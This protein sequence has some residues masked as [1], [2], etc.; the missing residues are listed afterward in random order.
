MRGRPSG[1]FSFLVSLC[2]DVRIFSC[3]IGKL[4]WR[5]A[6]SFGCDCRNLEIV[7]SNVGLLQAI[8]WVESFGFS[9]CNSVCSMLR[10]GIYPYLSRLFGFWSQFGV[11]NGLVGVLLRWSIFK[12]TS[13]HPVYVASLALSWNP[14]LVRSVPGV[15][16]S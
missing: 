11:S 12:G 2:T 7:F 9:L 10:R 1:R 14:F 8:F 16:A 15:S 4:I 3:Q 5:T 13:H 6:S